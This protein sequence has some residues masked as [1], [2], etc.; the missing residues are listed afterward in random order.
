MAGGAFRR[1]LPGGYS[2]GLGMVEGFCS[3]LGQKFVLA[4]CAARD[5]ASAGI[6]RLRLGIWNA[7][8]E[9]CGEPGLR[10]LAWS[11]AW[12]AAAGGAGAKSAGWRHCSGVEYRLRRRLDALGPEGFGAWALRALNRP[13]AHGRGSDPRW[14][15][16]ARSRGWLCAGPGLDGAL[17]GALHAIA[18]AGGLEQGYFLGSGFDARATARALADGLRRTEAS[19]PAVSRIWG[20]GAAGGA[21]AAG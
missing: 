17:S 13:R 19:G 20:Q 18:A 3:R 9:P 8:G 1:R 12:R 10:A 7:M 5:A 14:I 15:W 4:E 2:A 11:W 6:L 21:E 16:H